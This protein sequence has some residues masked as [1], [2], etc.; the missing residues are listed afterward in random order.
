MSVIIGIDPHKASHTAV[1]LDASEGVLGQRRVRAGQNQ[2][3]ELLKWAVDF[4]ERSWAIE[5]AGG[6]GYLLSQELVAAGEAVFDVPATLASRVRALGTGRSKKN[7]PN[8]A[9]SVAV[10]ALRSSGLRQV[11]AV[12]HSEVLRLLAKRNTDIGNLRCQ[13]VERV[14]ALVTELVGGGIKKEL[15]ASDLQRF[16]DQFVPTTEVERIRVELVTELLEDIRRLDALL[17]A[18][19]RRI[20]DAVRASGTS[21][22][23]MFGVGP[24]IAA[25]VIGYSGDIARFANRDH[26]AAYNGTAPVEYSSGG[27]VSHRPSR[28]G[29]PQPQPRNSHGGDQPAPPSHSEG[30]AYFDRRVDEGKTRREA[31][32]ALKRHLSNAVYRHL[33]ADKARAIAVV[34]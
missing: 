13:A 33:V 32:R 7:D 19:H 10:A 2:T 11:S 3:E 18:S 17:K 6:L 20:R 30:R 23:E 22:T 5:S 21:V 16:L 9:T 8:D 31:L 24:V 14:H 4:P 15:Y 27:R 1:A 25:I 26:Y 29:K 34:R 12:G 28:R